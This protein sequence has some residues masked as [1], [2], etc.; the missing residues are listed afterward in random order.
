MICGVFSASI[1]AELLGM[2]YR[3]NSAKYIGV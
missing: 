1:N 3:Y 2:E